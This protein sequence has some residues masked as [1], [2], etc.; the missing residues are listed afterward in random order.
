VIQLTRKINN[1]YTFYYTKN[2]VVISVTMYPEQEQFV[3][4]AGVSHIFKCNNRRT[5]LYYEFQNLTKASLVSI[6]LHINHF[7]EKYSNTY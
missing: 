6:S 1:Y 2:D 3:V 5:K 7:V 4:K